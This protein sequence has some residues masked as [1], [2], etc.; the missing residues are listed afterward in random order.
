MLF[1]MGEFSIE[2]SNFARSSKRAGFNA[3]ERRQVAADFT[4]EKDGVTF[5][6]LRDRPGQVIDRVVVTAVLRRIC[7]QEESKSG[8]EQD[9]QAL[10]RLGKVLFDYRADDSRVEKK[11]LDVQDS[12]Y[13][14]LLTIFL[15]NFSESELIK[16]IYM[17]NIKDG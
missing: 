4:E 6:G 7:G 1:D 16:K 5:S 17:F 2:L 12:K 13:L 15:E 14:N 10:Q 9:R 11:K 3:A 8:W